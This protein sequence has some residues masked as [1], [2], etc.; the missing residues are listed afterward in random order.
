MPKAPEIHINTGVPQPDAREAGCQT[1]H[2]AYNKLFHNA[3]PCH[4]EKH[5]HEVDDDDGYDD[6]DDD[7]GDGDG[8]DDGD[9]D[10]VHDDDDD[11]DNEDGV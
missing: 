9:E 1:K 4:E 10:G 2:T 7:E 6:D 5:G 3:K 8:N 11:D